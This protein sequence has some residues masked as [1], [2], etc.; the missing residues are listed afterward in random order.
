MHIMHKDAVPDTTGR[1]IRG[2]TVALSGKNHGLL[3][4]EI[5]NMHSP[6]LA[7][8]REK[9]NFAMMQIHWPTTGKAGFAGQKKPNAY[10]LED[11]YYP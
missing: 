11:N 9:C 4:L 2:A 7:F 10:T 1:T 6:T 8:L 3:M 5:R